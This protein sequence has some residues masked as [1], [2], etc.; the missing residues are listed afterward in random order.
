MLIYTENANTVA[1]FQSLHAHPPYNSI[2]LAAVDILLKYSVDL[3]IEFIPG[4]ENGIADALSCYQNEK[5]LELAPQASIFDFEPP[6][7]VLGAAKKW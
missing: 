7:K 4:S 5:V 3:C 6:W 2:M 1:M